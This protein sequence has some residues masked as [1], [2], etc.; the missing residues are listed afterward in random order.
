MKNFNTS[1]GHRVPIIF[2]NYGRIFQ[3]RPVTLLSVLVFQG[4]TEYFKI[5]EFTEYSETVTEF[6]ILEQHTCTQHTSAEL[7][8]SQRVISF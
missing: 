6:T 3:Y 2:H 7:K 8:I 5:T 1:R 4:V